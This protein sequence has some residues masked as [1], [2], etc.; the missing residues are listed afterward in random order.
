MRLS[1]WSRWHHHATSP[2][3]GRQPRVD[4][5]PCRGW[6]WSHHPHHHSST[7]P[8]RRRHP[9]DGAPAPGTLPVAG[10][11]SPARRRGAHMVTAAHQLPRPAPAPVTRVQAGHVASTLDTCRSA[12]QRS[13]WLPCL[14]ATRR[15]SITAPVQCGERKSIH[16]NASNDTL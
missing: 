16:L 5:S 10:Q 3:A 7:G 2:V 4:T 1:P 13:A 12:E 11:Q 6:R 15:H 14:A 9:A 8:P